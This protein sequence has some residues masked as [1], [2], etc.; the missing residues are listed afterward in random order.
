MITLTA[1]VFLGS[2]FMAN[3]TKMAFSPAPLEI[4]VDHTVELRNGGL[5]IINDTV[6]LSAKPAEKVAPLRSFLIGFPLI[7]RSNL[8]YVYAFDPL[9]QRLEVELDVGLGKP[10]FYAVKVI[11][12]HPIDISGEAY[13]FTVTFVFSDMIT[14]EIFPFERE[15]GKGLIRFNATFP[16]APSL[17]NS[18]SAVNLTIILPDNV[19][20]IS[21]SFHKNNVNLTKRTKGAFQIFNHTWE[22]MEAFVHK[23]SWFQ[24]GGTQENFL[25]L[26]ALEIERVIKIENLKRVLLTD[27]YKIMPKAVNLSKLRVQLVPGAYEIKAWDSFERPFGKG[28][29]KIEAG[30]VEEPVYVTLTFGRPY[31]RNK[32]GRFRLAYLVPW[33]NVV[34]QISWQ[35]YSLELSIPSSFDWIV[36]KLVITLVLPE[37]AEFVGSIDAGVIQKSAFQE[38]L[39]ITYYNVTPF[40]EII[41]TATYDYNVLWFSFRPTLWVGVAVAII[42]VLALLWRA[43]KPAAPI[44]MIPVKP[45]ELK[46]YV[47]SYEEKRR[48]LRMLEILEE[49]ARK[50][51]IPR[52]RYKV[53]KRALESR[54]SVLSKDLTRLR[55]KLRTASTKYADMMRQIEI[56][57]A[58]LE[59]IEAGIRRTETRYRRGEISTAAYH[60]LLE[61][62]YRRRERAR[63]TIDGIILRL[64]EEI[65]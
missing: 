6:E 51:K 58:E 1:L 9:G 21:S 23:P 10:G 59:G 40:H 20:F 19:D 65:A 41:Q 29:L 55:E 18:A 15:P 13:E 39:T 34:D 44:P 14:S 35:R 63:T 28:G 64:K 57:E 49:K 5:T 12:P 62:Y 4:Q 43:P 46:S 22:D 26:E 32:P 7:Y 54:L 47:D 36:R 45:E 31:E 24:F 11:F 52:R 42:G 3:A 61:D 27:T 50:G 17:T 30:K 53:R 37:G 8:A 60:K 16:A 48:S 33:R 25:I 2:P 38:S 56:A